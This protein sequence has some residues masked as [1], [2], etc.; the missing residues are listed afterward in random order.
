LFLQGS[1]CIPRQTRPGSPSAPPG[2]LQTRQL[3]PQPVGRRDVL[4]NAQLSRTWGS[5]A[6]GIYTL[7]DTTATDFSLARLENFG[8]ANAYDI[9]GGCSAYF[10]RGSLQLVVIPEPAAA[11]LGGLGLLALLRR[12]QN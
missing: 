1:E 6:D 4:R 10:R 12:R 5:V 2:V 9:G 11:L 3:N 7:I 8:L